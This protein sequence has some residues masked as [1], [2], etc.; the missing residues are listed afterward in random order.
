MIDAPFERHNVASETVGNEILATCL[1]GFFSFLALCAVLLMVAQA[2]A[3][4]FSTTAICIGLIAGLCLAATVVRIVRQ[5]AYVRTSAQRWYLAGALILGT[6]SGVLAT[7]INRPDIDD[8]IYVPKPV[9]YLEHPQE[10]ID[11]Q[12]TWL[13]AVDQRPISGVFPYY[14]LTQAGLARLT[15]LPYLATYHVL[16]PCI[17]GFLMTAALL[18]LLGCFESTSRTVLVCG[19]FYL[20]LMLAL[21][22]THRSYG[23][24]SIAR[25]FHGKYMFMSVGTPGWIYLSLRY[26]QQPTWPR[27]LILAA[28]GIAMAAATPTA[29]VFLPFLAMTI[30]FAYQM[31]TARHRPTVAELVLALR[32]GTTL[33]PVVVMAIGFRFYAVDNIAAGSQINAGFPKSFAD[34]L[35]LIV[36]PDFPL[37]PWLFV[38]SLVCVLGFS[39]YR[40]FFGGWVLLLAVMLLNPLI[41]DAVIQHLTTE[42]IYWRMFYLLPFPLLPTLALATLM[43]AGRIGTAFS[44]LLVTIAG[45]LAWGGPT[46]VLRPEN[47]ATLAMP[48]YKIGRTDLATSQQVIACGHAGSILAPTQIASNILLLSSRFPQYEM[49]DDYLGLM[50]EKVPSPF[51]LQQRRAA[52]AYLYNDDISNDAERAFQML[53]GSKHRPDYILAREGVVNHRSIAKWLTDAGYAGRCEITGGYRLFGRASELSQ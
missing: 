34:Q 35:A 33:L 6:L 45:W 1:E 15:G 28:T 30:A 22:E 13:A 20:L 43:H 40:L 52:S 11:S 8:S 50:L 10:P 21:G 32:Y 26:L 29:M 46:S 38:T 41:S 36:N 24:L 16:F 39:R 3:L 44:L 19:A 51:S 2:V 47:G 9:F 25:A 4:A 5:L 37:T 27:W 53:I 23:N 12:V 48:G 42:N 7:S 18:V 14:E 49:R 31:Q 17:V